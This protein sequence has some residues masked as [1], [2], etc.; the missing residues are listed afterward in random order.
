[1]EFEKVLN[2]IIKYLNKEIYCNMNDWQEVI[3][4]VA[5]GRVIGNPNLKQELINNTYV[6]TF[7][8]MD[9]NGM[10]DIDNL[11]KD[12]KNQIEQKG[13]ITFSL[14]LLG[15]FTFTPEDVEKLHQT[16]LEG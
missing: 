10:V 9:S 11:M 12:L 3:S 7:G 5:V 14:P 1:M 8:I 13:K 6:K 16:I 15:T 2:G 4:R